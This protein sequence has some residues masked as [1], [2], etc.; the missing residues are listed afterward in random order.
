[1]H[2]ITRPSGS[3]VNDNRSCCRSI[4]TGRPAASRSLRS[5]CSHFAKMALAGD[6]LLVLVLAKDVFIQRHVGA[7][8]VLEES[9]GALGGSENAV[10]DV[11]DVDIDADCTHH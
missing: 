11:V 6:R 2:T 8:I 9:R 3:A 4:G 1:M 5:R 10:T 7:A